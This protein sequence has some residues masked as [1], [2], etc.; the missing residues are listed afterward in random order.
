MIPVGLDDKDAP[1]VDTTRIIEEQPGALIPRITPKLPIHY[2]SHKV[3]RLGTACQIRLPLL[4]MTRLQML[5]MQM[6]VKVREKVMTKQI[7]NLLQLL[8][9]GKGKLRWSS[10]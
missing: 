4:M 2:S 3:K 1:C 7:M 5:M 8:G 10:L 9:R 6:R